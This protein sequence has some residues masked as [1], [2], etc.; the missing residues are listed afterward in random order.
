MGARLGIVEVDKIALQPGHFVAVYYEDSTTEPEIGRCARVA[1]NES[2]VTLVWYE[3]TYSSQWKPWKIRDPKEKQKII[4]WIDTVPLSSI[5][6]YAFE[7]T[8]KQHQKKQ[9]R[10]GLNW[11]MLN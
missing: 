8:P 7:L 6:L 4:E 5:L 10:Q 9:Q 1:V 3:G 2:E 11:I